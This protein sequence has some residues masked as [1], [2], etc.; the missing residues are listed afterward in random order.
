MLQIV[1][2]NYS[3]ASTLA[4]PKNHEKLQPKPN[5]W[6]PAG[7]QSPQ[8]CMPQATFPGCVLGGQ[9]L[10]Q[11]RA[12]SLLWRIGLCLSRQWACFLFTKAAVPTSPGGLAPQY[13]PFGAAKQAVR[14]CKTAFF[15]AP[16]GAYCILL[17]VS[18]LRCKLALG[19]YLYSHWLHAVRRW[20]CLEARLVCLLFC[21]C[22]MSRFV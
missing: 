12:E 4:I 13:V 9:R 1:V 6:L 5:A 2:Q 17:T 7:R 19:K 16:N 10:S 15:A 8:M 21:H 11:W 22:A 20:R 14:Q 18:R 3:F